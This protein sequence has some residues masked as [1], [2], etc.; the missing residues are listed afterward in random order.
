M[1][2]QDKQKKTR[3]DDRQLPMQQMATTNI[4][5]RKGKGRYD[6]VQV[7]FHEVSELMSCQRLKSTL[8]CLKG[9]IT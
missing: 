5:Q 6:F 7:V 4:V 3:F 9:S 1:D 8:D 2:G